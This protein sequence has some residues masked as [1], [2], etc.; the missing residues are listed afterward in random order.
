MSI[1]QIPLRLATGAFILNSGL[2]KRS[3][4]EEQAA[5]MRDMGAKG[6]PYLSEL[7]PAQFKQ[8]IVATEVGVGGALLLP[9]VP[10]WL[11]GAA[12]TAFSGGL[13]SM[14]LNT[15]EMTQQDGVR[16]SGEGTGLAKDVFMVGS[17]LA[18]MADSVANRPG[19][20]R[21][22]AKKRA[23]RIED[24]RDAKVQAIRDA[25]D[26]KVAAIFEARDQQTAALR[27]AR[28]ELKKLR[29]K[30]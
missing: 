3:L 27:D 25:K 10:G 30:A 22:A 2:G 24:A 11:A 6:V 1:V 19:K 12:L 15:P 28:D 29:K 16:P 13:M 9:L 21:K 8:F 18:I 23:R 26:E 20:R 17:G 14:Y 7:S 4:S 5:G